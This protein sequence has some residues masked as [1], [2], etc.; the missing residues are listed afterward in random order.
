[1]NVR[2][3]LSTLLALAVLAAVSFPGGALARPS[4]ESCAAYRAIPFS[5]PVPDA[6]RTAGTH[7]FE[8]LSS[9]QNFDGTSGED[10]A[11]NQMT[12][13]SSAPLYSSTVLLRLVRNTALLPGGEVVEV[14]EM[15]PSQA[16]AFY[17][18]AFS[19]HGDDVFL[20]SFRTWFRYETSKNHWT[21]WTELHR[22]PVTNY[23]NQVTT[24]AWKKSYGWD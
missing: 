16:A 23:C 5:T 4:D 14:T 13:A 1:M 20:D 11:Q 10:L 24:S 12:I 6:F 7:R 15:H 17:I 18:A 19:V 21:P 9:Y 22:G 8:W 2:G 3:R